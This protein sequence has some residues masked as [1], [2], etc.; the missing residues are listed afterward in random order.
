MKN[1]Y[2]IGQP[3]S[4]NV[5]YAEDEKVAKSLP[6]ILFQWQKSNTYNVGFENIED[7]VY[8]QYQLKPSDKYIRCLVRDIN[9]DE[10]TY[11]NTIEVLKYDFKSNARK[12]AS[13][14]TGRGMSLN[15]IVDEDTGESSEETDT[16]LIN[17]SI[18]IILSTDP[19]ETPIVN[20]GCDIPSM[21]FEN[22]TDD[23]LNRIKTVAESA[24]TTQQPKIKLT[25]V[26]VLYDGLYTITIKV[27]YMIKN[28]NI[29]SSHSTEL[30]INI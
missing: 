26:E 8:F 23:L 28:T 9:T 10:Y 15:D 16:G 12:T 27:T 3:Y 1:Y 14:V 4:G 19:T 25:N 18:D 21:L 24:L 13:N 22:V 2:I 17:Q 30:H 5:V 29:R 11:T 20:V 7:Q 6:N